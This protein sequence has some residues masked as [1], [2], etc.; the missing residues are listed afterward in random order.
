[1]K[2]L[3]CFLL[4]FSLLLTLCSCGVSRFDTSK[5]KAAFQDTI[6]ALFQALDKKDAD[7]VYDLFAP[8]VQAHSAELKDQ[9]EKFL[10]AYEGPTDEIG[11]DGAVSGGSESE[12]KHRIEYVLSTFPVRCGDTYYWFYINL[13]YHN[14]YDRTQEGITQLNF[15][16]ADE[17]YLFRGEDRQFTEAPGLN[18]YLAETVDEEVRCIEQYPYKYSAET[19]PLLVN[20]AIDFLNSSADFTEFKAQFGHPNAARG[21]SEDYYYVCYELAT[22]TDKT[23]YLYI[24]V[25]DGTIITMSIVD[26][27]RYIETLFK[28]EHS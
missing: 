4:S 21:F 16:T 20:D 25:S 28:A 13:T 1:M 8:S 3:F 27:F 18:L 17:Y 5:E 19:T 7:A 2:R 9:V 11:W 12:G 10:S 22:D 6:T 24:T 14:T 23:Q 15:Y 26:D